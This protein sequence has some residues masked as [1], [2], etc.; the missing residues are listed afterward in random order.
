M[1]SYNNKK[2]VYTFKYGG[3]GSKKMKVALVACSVVMILLGII[4]FVILYLL[5]E[6]GAWGGLIPAVA[7]LSML[8]TFLYV[9]VNLKRHDKIILQWLNDENLFETETEPWEFD[10]ESSQS[11]FNFRFGVDFEMN[12]EQYRK[13]SKGYDGFYKI[14]K[15]K[16]IKILYSP[17]YDQVMILQ[18]DNIK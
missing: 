2:I 7:G 17:K 4:C 18:S 16:K 1:V 14:I 5:E 11:T 10:C 13:I 12:G 6:D 15:D 9:N 3:Y 8:I